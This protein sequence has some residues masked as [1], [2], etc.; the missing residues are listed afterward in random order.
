[1]SL[2]ELIRVNRSLLALTRDHVAWLT[3]SADLG[4]LRSLLLVLLPPC[5]R[6]GGP[7]CQSFVFSQM[8]FFLSS[9]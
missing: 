7:S 9:Y 5:C 2:Q 4:F 1:M 8:S 3:M 6:S